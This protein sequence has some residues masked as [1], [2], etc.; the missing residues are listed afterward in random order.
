MAATKVDDWLADAER[1]KGH[2]FDYSRVK[3]E[4]VNASIPVTIICREHNREFKVKPVDHMRRNSSC[5][6]C[7][8]RVMAKYGQGFLIK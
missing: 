7:K 8:K 4:W 3:D 5:S 6:V 2:R 1:L